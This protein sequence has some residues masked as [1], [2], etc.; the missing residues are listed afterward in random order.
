MAS[1]PSAAFG[2]THQQFGVAVNEG[3]KRPYRW[4]HDVDPGEAQEDFLPQCP[5][6]QVREPRADTPV[7]A[8]AEGQLAPRIG[9]S[10]DEVVGIG[11][12][13]VVAVG[14]Q[15]PENDLVALADT[16]PA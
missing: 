10:Q 7:D 5:D 9:A 11:E 14:L 4:L 13:R 12:N 6:L 16:L 15:I 1:A 3:G 8:E 2:D